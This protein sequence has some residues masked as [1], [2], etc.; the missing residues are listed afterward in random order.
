MIPPGSWD[1][2]ALAL[3]GFE[4]F[5]F[6]QVLCDSRLSLKTQRRAETSAD[7]FVS[8]P[9]IFVSVDVVKR[10]LPKGVG[11]IFTFVGAGAENFLHISGGGFRYCGFWASWV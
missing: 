3:G 9:C 7:V 5:G 8:G 11:L 1:L 4:R 2:T 10:C 6:E